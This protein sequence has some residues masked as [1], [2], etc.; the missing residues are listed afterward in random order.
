MHSYITKQNKK[1]IGFQSD[2]SLNSIHV[3]CV[4]QILFKFFC[5]DSTHQ[6]KREIWVW[7]NLTKFHTFLRSFWHTIFVF[8]GFGSC[9]T[10]GVAKVFNVLPKIIVIHTWCFGIENV[11]RFATKLFSFIL[12]YIFNWTRIF[13]I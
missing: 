1:L 6:N 2:Q 4:F 11:R 3:R 13:I 9:N 10:L 8:I 5:P 12:P 7:R